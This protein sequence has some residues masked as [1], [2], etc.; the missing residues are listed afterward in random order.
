MI[1]GH[2]MTRYGA[3]VALLSLAL[4][5]PFVSASEEPSYAG[6]ELRSIKSLSEQEIESLRRGD[7]MGFAKL[8]ELNHFPGPRHVLDLSRELELSSRQL[9]DTQALYNEMLEH[10]RSLGA[11]IVEAETELDRRFELGSITAESLQTALHDIGRLRAELRYV[12]LRAHLRQ[13]ELLSAEQVRK[14]DALRGYGEALDD[15]SK[16]QHSQPVPSTH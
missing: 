2:T 8:A 12:H 1:F 10:A 13:R 9:A 6:Q 5:F 7:G 14:Y 4:V 3:T 15:H 16:H 11:G